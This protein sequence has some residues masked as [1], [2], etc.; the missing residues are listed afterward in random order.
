MAWVRT[1]RPQAKFGFL[2]I[3]DGTFFECLQ[4]VYGKELANFE[5]ISKLINDFEKSK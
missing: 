3:N 1:N 4:I 5:E 2:S